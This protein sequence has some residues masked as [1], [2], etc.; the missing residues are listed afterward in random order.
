MDRTKTME[1]PMFEAFRAHFSRDSASPS[2]AGGGD[3]ETMAPALRE[4]LGEFGGASFNQGLY[5]VVRAGDAGAWAAR[6]ALAF[7]AFQGRIACF[8]YDWLGRAFALDSGRLE[9]GAPGVTLFDVGTG[10]A[11]EIPAD[12]A[13]FHDDILIRHAEPALA[14]DFH[15]RWLASGGAAPRHSECVGYK[16]P[17]FLSGKDELENLEIGDLDV[18]WHIFGQIIAKLHAARAAPSSSRP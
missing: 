8:G 1:R 4:L 5:R 10:Q 15:R 12:I 6:V 13:A 2:E 7:P 11:L 18:Y 14:V 3:I 9:G 17:L 16:K